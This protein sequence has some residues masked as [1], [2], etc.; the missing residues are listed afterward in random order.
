MHCAGLQNAGLATAVNKSFARSHSGQVVDQ[1]EAAWVWQHLAVSDDGQ[2]VVALTY[3]EGAPS[4][5]LWTDQD[6]GQPQLEEDCTL[7]RIPVLNTRF[8]QRSSVLT[9]LKPDFTCRTLAAAAV[10]PA[11][12]V[13]VG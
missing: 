10:G 3:I 8:R 1:A 4:L 13:R 9:A 2:A 7:V 12:P 11:M 5:W 6:A